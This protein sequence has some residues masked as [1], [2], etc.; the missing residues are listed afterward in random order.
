M[1][2]IY[3]KN[4]YYLCTITMYLGTV[5]IK[6]GHLSTSKDQLEPEKEA[7]SC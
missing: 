7:D 2:I 1:S 5:L 3:A 6:Q 4:E